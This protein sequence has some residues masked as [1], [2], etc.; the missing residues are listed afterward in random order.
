MV[1]VR[2]A[3][4]HRLFLCFSLYDNRYPDGAR[5]DI[6]CNTLGDLLALVTSTRNYT[7]SYGS[8]MVSYAYHT[9]TIR[10]WCVQTRGVLQYVLQSATA[11][12]AAYHIPGM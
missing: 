4:H 5:I 11:A 2:E 8:R 6:D 10:I 9:K 3:G 1:A 12:P 7:I